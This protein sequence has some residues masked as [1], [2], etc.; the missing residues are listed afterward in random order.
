MG[1]APRDPPRA[2]PSPLLISQIGTVRHGEE[3]GHPGQ[4]VAV[5]GPNPAQ[6]SCLEIR[7]PLFYCTGNLT[8]TSCRLQ[9]AV[10][11]GASPRVTALSGGSTGGG[12]NLPHQAGM[13]QHSAT[14]RRRRRERPVETHSLSPWGA[15][16]DGYIP[17]PSPVPGVTSRVGHASP[18]A[19]T[20]PT[21]MTSLHVRPRAQRQ[22]L[23]SPR[24]P[25]PCDSAIR[26]DVIYSH[27][28]ATSPGANDESGG[29]ERRTG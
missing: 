12:G 21:Q 2:W 24:S 10:A 13:Q 15:D 17:P 29:L 16:S 20:L 7:L 8:D 19:C 27:Q 28:Q 3:K 18:R 11:P 26:R 23:A 4:S 9:G 6:I 5:P 1:T 22:H 14:P 25:S